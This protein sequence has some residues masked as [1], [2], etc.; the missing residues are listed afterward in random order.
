MFQFYTLYIK[1][2]RIIGLSPQKHILWYVYSVIILI[3]LKYIMNCVNYN[4]H[5]CILEH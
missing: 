4:P 3:I 2:Y 1:L 5:Y